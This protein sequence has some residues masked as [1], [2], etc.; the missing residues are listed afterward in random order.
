MEAPQDPSELTC[1]RCA[2]ALAGHTVSG[3]TVHQC[4][5]GHGVF[6]E[7]ADLGALAEAENEWHRSAGP[8]AT[9]P[10]P[11]ITPGMT[12]PPPPPARARAFVDTLFS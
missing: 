3:V 12:A 6:L 8:A 11:R 9:Q 7:R 1:P 5:R 4:P 10:L 2:T